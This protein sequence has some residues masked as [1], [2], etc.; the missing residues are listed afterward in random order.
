[1]VLSIVPVLFADLVLCNTGNRGLVQAGT[2]QTSCSFLFSRMCTR[3]VLAAV[4]SSPVWLQLPPVTRAYITLSF[5]TTAG[6]ALE[7]SCKSMSMLFDASRS[8]HL[9]MC[10]VTPANLL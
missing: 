9:S 6:C 4:P 2:E 8:T 7:V 1:M 3:V 10:S 5:L